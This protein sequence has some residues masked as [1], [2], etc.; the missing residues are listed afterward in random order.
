MN[1]EERVRYCVE[2]GYPPEE[3]RRVASTWSGALANIDNAWFRLIDGARHHRDR[4]RFV[5]A[6]ALTTADADEALGLTEQMVGRLLR[7]GKL[8]GVKANSQWIVPLDALDE[9]VARKDE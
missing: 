8:R 5:R 2:A 4:E 7:A 9:F 6:K 3:A 1:H